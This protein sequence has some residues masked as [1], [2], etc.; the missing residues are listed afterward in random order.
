MNADVPPIDVIMVDENDPHVSDVGAKGLGELGI[1][2]AGA[3]IAN[4]VFHATGKRVRDVPITLD[5]LL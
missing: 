1:T 4:A 5:R 3:A 2:G